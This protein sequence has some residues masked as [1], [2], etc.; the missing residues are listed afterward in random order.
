MNKDLRTW[1]RLA[2][3]PSWLS[4]VAILDIPYGSQIS[5]PIWHAIK[6]HD[7][8]LAM[9]LTQSAFDSG[10]MDD[11]PEAMGLLCLLGNRSHLANDLF[12][13][14]PKPTSQTWRNRGVFA[15]WA[16]IFTFAAHAFAN[17]I[18]QSANGIWCQISLGLMNVL[19]RNHQA[20]TTLLSN[21]EAQKD[22]NLYALGHLSYMAAKW[23]TS[24]FAADLMPDI[25]L[26][27]LKSRSGNTLSLNAG[28]GCLPTPL[29]SDLILYLACDP[30]YL[31]RFGLAALS[32]FVEAH[33]GHNLAVHLHLYDPTDAAR[34]QIQAAAHNLGCHIVT[35]SE[36]SPQDIPSK[37]LGTY[38]ACARFCRLA[39][40]FPSYQ[41]PVIAIDADAL[42]RR[43]CLPLIQ[44][45][46]H[47]G[48]TWSHHT[49][50]WNRYP[51]GFLALQPT[52]TSHD[53]L[54]DVARIIDDSLSRKQHL[55]FL[56]QWAIVIAAQKLATSRHTFR[57]YPWQWT[58]NTEFGENA[59]VW[60]ANDARKHIDGI[61]LQEAARLRQIAL[62]NNCRA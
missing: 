8:Q 16:R 28:R 29:N 30:G 14:A 46:P 54:V 45:T 39:E 49:V 34:S 5:Q 50:P 41:A 19:A 40:A 24:N 23:E 59:F 12:Q 6:K 22:H 32:S 1:Q 35:T 15:L 55:W 57:K 51:A 13:M 38:Y 9:Q 11:I 26:H 43:N 7:F 52:Q 25:D 60:Q 33:A 27:V 18:D 3:A 47:I 61:Y 42:I 56:D 48:M 53:F 36:I 2:V 20:A 44:R 62:K 37:D 4:H 21:I 31:D 10:T 58:Y 17:G